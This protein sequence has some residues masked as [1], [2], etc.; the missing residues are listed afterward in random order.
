MIEIT[1]AG[2]RPVK[3]QISPVL[4]SERQRAAER[5]VAEVTGEVRSRGKRKIE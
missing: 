1:L 5:H 2:K 3:A 4:I